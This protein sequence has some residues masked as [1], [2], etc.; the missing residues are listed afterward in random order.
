MTTDPEVYTT[1]PPS[2]TYEPSL[3]AIMAAQATVMPEVVTSDVKGVAFNRFYNLWLEN[4]D[5]NVSL[6]KSG[7]SC[8]SCLFYVQLVA[9]LILCYS[10]GLRGRPQHAVDRQAGYQ[11]DQLL[12]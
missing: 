8:S 3:S 4:V 2:S 7:Q 1:R 12:W 5:A 6:P 11:L 9:N 10:P